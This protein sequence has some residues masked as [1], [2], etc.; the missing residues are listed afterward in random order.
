MQLPLSFQ[1]V[2]A[3]AGVARIFIKTDQ[4]SEAKKILKIKSEDKRRERSLRHTSGRYRRVGRT[5]VDKQGNNGEEWMSVAKGAKV[6]G[7]TWSQGVG[8]KHN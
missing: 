6:L 2:R 3:R 8:K 4:A 5:A 1:T 7:E